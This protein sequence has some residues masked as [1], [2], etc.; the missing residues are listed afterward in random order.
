MSLARQSARSLITV[1]RRHEANC[2]QGGESGRE[3][4]EKFQ[5]AHSSVNKLLEQRRI[6][7][8]QV[9]GGH[10]RAW[11]ELTSED[12]ELA[13]DTVES[14]HRMAWSQERSTGL[15]FCRI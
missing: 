11:I 10:Q 3:V 1:N 12:H 15:D 5:L 13:A 9:R 14:T 8:P 7:R 2:N 4:S 6:N